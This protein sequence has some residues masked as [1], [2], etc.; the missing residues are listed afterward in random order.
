MTF[1]QVTLIKIKRVI[2]RFKDSNILEHRLAAE[3]KSGRELR[4]GE[5]VHHKDRDK[6]NNSPNNL[7]VFKNQSE[8]DRVHKNDAQRFG[9]DYSYKGTKKNKK[10][11]WD[12]LF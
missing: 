12:D 9:K 2:K 8:H 6:T 4:T 3:K 10:G 7:H 11:F 5:V 1:F